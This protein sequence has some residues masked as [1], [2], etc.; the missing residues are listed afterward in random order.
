MAG[1]F[2]HVVKA[3]FLV[4]KKEGLSDEEFRKHYT[5][6]HAPMA[7]EVCKRHGVLDYN[8]VC[9]MVLCPLFERPTPP[10]DRGLFVGEY[11]ADHKQHFNTEAERA[12]ARAAFG[13]KATFIDCDAITTFIFPDMESLI[14]SFADPEYQEKLAPDERRFSNGQK[15]QFAVSDEFVVLANGE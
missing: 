5:E 11:G 1:T 15:S 2:R 3:T 12:V 9:V 7:L 8:I 14:G 6:V 13:E 4:S 10:T